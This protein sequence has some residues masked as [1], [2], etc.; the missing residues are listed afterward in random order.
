MNGV[1]EACEA[2]LRKAEHVYARHG[3]LLPCMWAIG[4]HRA[5]YAVPK[6]PEAIWHRPQIL[7]GAHALLAGTVDA[8][9]VGMNHEV[10]SQERDVDDPRPV[11]GDLARQAA[12]DPTIHTAIL[13]HALDIKTD[14]HTVGM[15]KLG[16]DRKGRPVWETDMRQNSSSP[17]LANLRLSRLLMVDMLVD[18][19]PENVLDSINW[20]AVWVDHSE[21]A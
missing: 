5:V 6:S 8:H 16:L 4:L 12:T 21:V 10:F 7:V 19:S 20:T 2:A 14:E 3:D 18:V 9:W 17:I 1:E 13:V 15:S 11:H